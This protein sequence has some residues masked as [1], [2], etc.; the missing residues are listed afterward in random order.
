MSRGLVQGVGEIV[1]KK[2]VPKILLLNGSHDRET[3]A[4][5]DHGGLM[6]AADV[7]K[8]VT[9]A[10]NRAYGSFQTQL[11]NPTSTYVTAILVPKGG[12]ISVD[13]NALAALGIRWGVAPAIG[14]LV[15]LLSGSQTT[16]WDCSC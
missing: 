3:S 16:T 5:M 1:A 2:D 7:V 4:S 10:L 8:A 13:V 15:L 9:S 14:R 6:T 12:A 11:Q